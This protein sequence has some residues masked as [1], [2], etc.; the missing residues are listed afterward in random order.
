MKTYLFFSKYLNNNIIDKVFCSNKN[1]KKGDENSN[2]TDFIYID[3][4]P[5]FKRKGINLDGI[6]GDIKIDFDE[7]YTNMTFLTNKS[8]LYEKLLEEDKN[9]TEKYLMKQYNLSKVNINSL[10]NIFDN[11]TIWILKPTFLT[12]KFGFQG[13]G[14]EIITDY[15]K[16]SNKINNI[17][18]I[19]KT[20]KIMHY[21]EKDI[22]DETW[23]IAEY[24]KNPLLFKM[25][26]FHLRLF[27]LVTKI[28][29]II[30]VYLFKIFPL[31]IAIKDYKK[32]NYNNKD[33]HDTHF[34]ESRGNLYFYPSDFLTEFGLEKTEIIN[35]QIF[36]VSKKFSN[37]IKKNIKFNCYP[38]ANNCYEIYGIDIMITENFEIKVLEFNKK[39]GIGTITEI[40][41]FSILFLEEL[42][43][44]T[45]NEKYEEKYHIKNNENYLIKL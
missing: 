32:E 17:F 15:S 31:I 41:Y 6:R 29:D 26:K 3:N 30:N 34:Q 16:L 42:I 11:N 14:I 21:F 33:I 44:I 10:R 2:Y 45:I 35:E 40:P 13:K 1:W 12:P 27:L 7:N 22:K 23:I 38:E 4:Y 19:L 37:Y 9:F 28:N 43:K 18:N 39:P 20:H 25:K 24:I 5:I 36:I 8:L